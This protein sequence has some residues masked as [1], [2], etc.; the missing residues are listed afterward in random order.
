MVVLRN[1]TG[2]FVGGKARWY[3]HGLDALTLEALVCRDVAVLA[4]TKGYRGS[5]W[6][7]T[8]KNC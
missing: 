4:E 5:L 7:L 2:T 1:D 6:R 3:P 8:V